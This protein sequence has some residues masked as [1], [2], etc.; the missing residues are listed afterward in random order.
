MDLK[1]YI[2]LATRTES[3]IEKVVVDPAFIVNVLYMF[4]SAGKMLDQIKKHVFYGKDY[5]I[6]RMSVNHQSISNALDDLMHVQLNGTSEEM[7]EEPLKGIDPRIFH[8]IVGIA[9]E[10]SEL[11]EALYEGLTGREIDLVNLGEEW[12]DECWYGAILVDALKG[13][14]NQILETNIEKLS[15]RY[16]D[17]FN[18]QKA[19]HRD[20]DKEREILEKGLKGKDEQS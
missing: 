19:I 8:A 6:A 15:K 4:T 12:G 16:P 11:C 18:A 17:K 2:E 9:T 5:D 3:K 13:D 7:G 14:W 10:S 1:E 20:T